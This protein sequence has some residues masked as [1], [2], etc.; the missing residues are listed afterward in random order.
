M[1][2]HWDSPS[3]AVQ[4]HLADPVG[5]RRHSSG[6]RCRS[7]FHHSQVTFP[8]RLKSSDQPRHLTISHS[9]AGRRARGPT[10]PPM[11]GRPQQ[12]TAHGRTSSSQ[13][14]SQ[15]ARSAWTGGTPAPPVP[16]TCPALRAASLLTRF[17]TLLFP[18][19]QN[20]VMVALGVWEVPGLRDPPQANSRA[21]SPQ[22]EGS[23]PSACSLP[24]RCRE[25]GDPDG[26]RCA[27]VPRPCSATVC[28]GEKKHLS[29]LSLL[30][31]PQ[32]T[33]RP[34][35]AVSLLSSLF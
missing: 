32:D 19:A 16:P 26:A 18:L 10:A 31:S 33:C 3:S 24:S 11:R 28:P 35:L 20:G 5:F 4:S 15:G 27:L 2:T 1:G 21:S 12:P 22:D 13:L 6:P 9:K 8:Q 25:N 34:F 23:R 7:S 30:L 17:C 14:E 29:L